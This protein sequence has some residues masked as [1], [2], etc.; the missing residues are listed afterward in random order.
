MKPTVLAALLASALAHGA[1]KPADTVYR[2]GYVYTVDAS[3]SVRQALAV[4]D[5]RI[6]YVGDNRGVQRY[7]GKRTEVIDLHGRMLMPGL[8]DGHMHPQSGGSRLLNCSL[9]YDKLTVAEFQSRI[10]GCLDRDSKAAP[11]AIN[12]EPMKSRRVIGTSIPSDSSWDMMGSLNQL[13][14]G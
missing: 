9:N 10:Q 4:R 6:V 14:R 1:E 13:T 12:V 2:N 8:I 3:D 7:T 5:G 11:E